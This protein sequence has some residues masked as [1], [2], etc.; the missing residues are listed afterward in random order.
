MLATEQGF[1]R[2][3]EAEGTTAAA[4][5]VVTASGEG[6][7]FVAEDGF[8]FGDEA[9]IGQPQE[10]Q[11]SSTIGNPSPIKLSTGEVVGM[12]SLPVL[13]AAL[14]AT[15]VSRLRYR[16]FNRAKRNEM[17]SDLQTLI[18]IGRGIPPAV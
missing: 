15:I 13:A 9:D 5:V 14:G 18:D 11:P 6:V 3:T 1:E 17:D 2:V 16:A 8:S 10:S 12:I 4:T 7:F